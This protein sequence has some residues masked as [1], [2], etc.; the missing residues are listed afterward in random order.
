[1]GGP[2]IAQQEPGFQA[3]SHRPLIEAQRIFLAYAAML[4]VAL[5]GAGMWYVSEALIQMSL[6]RFSIYLKLLACIGAAGILAPFAR[7]LRWGTSLTLLACLLIVVLIHIGAPGHEPGPAWLRDNLPPLLLFWAAAW[8]GLIHPQP[9]GPRA[10]AW[11]GAIGLGTALLL[12]IRHGDGIRTRLAPRDDPAYLAMCQWVRQPENTPKNARFLVPPQEQAFRLHAQRAIVVNY[13]GVGQLSGELGEWRRRLQDVLA[14]Q[15]LR[16]LP[17]RFDQTL[18]VI[19]QTYEA[20]P[21]EHLERV[22]RHYRA[23]YVLVGHELPEWQAK[24][25]HVSGRYSLYRLAAQ[26]AEQY[27]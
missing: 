22:A 20:L 5:L 6:Y 10:L 12:I 26:E 7:T 13:K 4:A 19:G 1:M 25:V 27:P 18:W 15:D 3:S 21:S 23:D 11:A 17:R 16:T 2:P 24:R 14:L 8:L 9:F